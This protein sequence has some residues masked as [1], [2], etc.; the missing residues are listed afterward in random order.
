MKIQYKLRPLTTAERILWENLLL[1][2][3]DAQ[4]WYYLVSPRSTTLWPVG[5]IL[6]TQ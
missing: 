6:M 1:D 4:R 2:E 5:I 3:M